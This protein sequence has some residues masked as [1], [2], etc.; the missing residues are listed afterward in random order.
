MPLLP[1][2]GSSLDA[3][4]S[5]LRSL[6]TP[7][8]TS[9]FISTPSHPPTSGPSRAPLTQPP[10]IA[11]TFAP[12]PTPLTA[13]SASPMFLGE[14][15]PR[16]TGKMKRAVLVDGAGDGSPSSHPRKR[17]RSDDDVHL[18]PG[19]RQAMYMQSQGHEE[20]ERSAA[21]RR[22]VA[23]SESRNSPQSVKPDAPLA[24]GSDEAGASFG[25]AISALDERRLHSVPPVSVKPEVVGTRNLEDDAEI[26]CT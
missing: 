23:G 11:T 10:A 5:S 21:K 7:P 3:S 15:S 8:K 25:S 24:S 17:P 19:E 26:V 20:A 18:S 22:R 1:V 6:A 9:P 14:D 12:K 2:A 16:R 4:G 13:I